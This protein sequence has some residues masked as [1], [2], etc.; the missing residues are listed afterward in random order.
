M[1]NLKNG[2]GTI[3][4]IIFFMVGTTIGTNIDNQVNLINSIHLLVS[5]INYVTGY[6]DALQALGRARMAIKE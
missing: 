3:G 5:K 4:T 2:K 1:K 6:K